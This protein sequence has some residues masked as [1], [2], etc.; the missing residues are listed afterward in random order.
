MGLSQAL[1]GLA[2][3][4]SCLNPWFSCSQ[5][6]GLL[7]CLPETPGFAHRIPE[8]SGSRKHVSPQHSPSTALPRIH[9]VLGRH[10]WAGTARVS[11]TLTQAHVR[12]GWG[13]RG[14]QPSFAVRPLK[15]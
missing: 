2:A 3:P 9:R 1:A 12:R 4:G 7:L 15:A 13:T 11:A 14:A 10:A 5:D 8:A 6:P